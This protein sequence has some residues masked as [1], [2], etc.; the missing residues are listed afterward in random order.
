MTAKA[1]MKETIETAPVSVNG[2]M[3]PATQPDYKLIAVE[4][5]QTSPTNPRRRINEQTIQSLAESIRTQGVLEPLIVRKADEKYEIVCGERRYRAAKVATI[6]E[7]PCLVRD[8]TDEQVLD[9]QI[10]ENLH[11]EDV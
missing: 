4:E 5:L 2:N 10:H 8:L 3:S 9:I 1:V 11:R 7:L 6:S